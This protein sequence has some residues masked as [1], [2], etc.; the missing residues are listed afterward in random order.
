MVQRIM[1]PIHILTRQSKKEINGKLLEIPGYALPGPMLPLSNL[2]TSVSV[3]TFAMRG[4]SKAPAPSPRVFLSLYEQHH[5][6]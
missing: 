3:D 6:F 4:Y 2:L 1:I 5:E